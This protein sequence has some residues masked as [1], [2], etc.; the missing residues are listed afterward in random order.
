MLKANASRKKTYRAEDLVKLKKKIK[1]ILTEAEKKD[2]EEDEKYGKGKGYNDM[3]E[4]LIDRKERQQ[5]I[6]RLLEKLKKIEIAEQEI[7]EKQKEAKTTEEKNRKNSQSH[8]LTDG[9]AALMKMKDGKVYKPAYNGQVS[10]SNQVVVA[11]GVS[12]DNV[13]TPLLMGMINTSERNTGIRVKKVK[14]DASYFS[15]ANIE[16]LEEKGID[17]YIPD[18]DKQREE[19]QE[20][21]KE[22]PAYDR[23]NFT[24]EATADEYVCPENQ[25]LKLVRTDQGTKKYMSRSCGECPVKSNCTQGKNRY[26]TIDP[27]LDKYKTE[28]RKKL[29]TEKGKATYVERMSEVEPVFGNIIYN[30]NAGHFLCRGKPMVKVEFGLSCIAHNLIKIANWL[31]EKNQTIRELQLAPLMRLPAVA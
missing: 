27:Q 11:Y 4:H 7:V 2:E 28:M 31:K 13:D 6:E 3:P 15:K 10:A 29:N 24:Y 9:G 5:E 20:K 25:R 12:D 22:I 16:K 19:K 23:R 14:A 1:G 30:Q 17:G 8:N 26:V 18:R 21:A